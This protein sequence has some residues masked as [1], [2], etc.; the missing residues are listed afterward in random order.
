[1]AWSVHRGLVVYALKDSR[2]KLK[3]PCGVP[4]GT[5]VLGEIRRCTVEL[6]MR[7]LRD[8]V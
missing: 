4:M 6:P 1:M 3:L 7:G 5:L 2:A 8:G